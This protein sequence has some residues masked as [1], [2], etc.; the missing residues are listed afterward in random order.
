MIFFK[1]LFF[2]LL[3]FWLTL[4]Q[5]H[6]FVEQ[7]QPKAGEELNSSPQAIVLTYNKNI[8]PTFSTIQII[9]VESHVVIETDKA[10]GVEGQSNKL[11]LSLPKLTKGEYRVR[12]VALSRDGHRTMGDYTFTIQ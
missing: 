4:V 10:K 8:E 7:Q 6:A 5:A 3:Q 2:I 9:N 12:W 1:T 11:V